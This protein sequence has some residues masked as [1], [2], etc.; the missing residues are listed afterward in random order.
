VE[1][2]ENRH[3][4]TVS[5]LTALIKSRLEESIG[6][7]WVEGE[8]S[9][10]RLYSSGHAYFSLKDAGSLVKAVLFKYRGDRLRFR[11]EDGRQVLVLGQVSCYSQRGDLQIVVETMEP[12]GAGSLQVAFEQLKAKLAAEGLFDEARKRPIPPMPASVGVVTSPDGAAVRD[13]IHVMRRRSAGTGIVIVPCRVQGDGAA[14]E[15]ADGIR[16]LNEWG[17]VEVI[18]VGRGGGSMEDLWAFNEEE[19]ARAIHASGIPVISAVGHETDFTIADFTADLRAPT[20][21]AAAEM[22]VRNRANLSREL[23][24]LAARLR[25]AVQSDLE[26]RR[27]RLT[28]LTD[29]RSLRDPEAFLLQPGQRLDDARSGLERVT[30]RRL[31]ESR[32]TVE[33]LAG[34]LARFHPEARL[35][36]FR[37]A[38]ESLE[39]RLGRGVAAAFERLRGALVSRA[40]RLD[41]LSPL[42]VLGRGYGICRSV[43]DGRVISDAT[44]V[45][46]GDP[47][48]IILHRGRLDATV[49]GATG[50]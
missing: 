48:N 25:E 31:A 50:G 1:S 46:P 9:G 4:Y 37:A 27:A 19:V 24:S 33:R 32:V 42:A 41:A 35:A 39:H 34:R 29:R 13:I 5:Q 26:H 18:I 49:T 22:V 7:V 2:A 28:G 8:I 43:P 16:A 36:A 15:I 40:G 17:G 20:P 45:A 47:I 12:R 3:I 30:G 11:P 23:E 44:T 6:M 21:S 14:A 10:Y 38:R